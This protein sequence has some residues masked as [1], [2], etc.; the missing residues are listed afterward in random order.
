M[1]PRHIPYQQI[2]TELSR[3]LHSSEC[4]IRTHHRVV[5]GWQRRLCGNW[6]DLS[7]EIVELARQNAL[8]A[9]GLQPRKFRVSQPSHRGNG[10]SRPRGTYYKCPGC[11]AMVLMPCKKCGVTTEVMR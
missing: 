1:R 6:R 9:A 5:S 7:Q 4:D 10:I 2:R 3:L 11:G 8:E